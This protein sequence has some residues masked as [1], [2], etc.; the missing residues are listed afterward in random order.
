MSQPDGRGGKE[1]EN[2]WA[3]VKHDENRH[4]KT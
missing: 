2:A 4:G 3:E 1:A